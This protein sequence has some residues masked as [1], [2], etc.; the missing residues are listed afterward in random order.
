MAAVDSLTLQVLLSGAGDLGTIGPRT[1]NHAVTAQDELIET[2]FVV[3]TTDADR[4]IPIP[5]EVGT[6][7]FLLLKASVEITFKINGGSEVRTLKAGI[8]HIEATEINTIEVTGGATDSN[9]QMFAV[10]VK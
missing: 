1:F 7:E 10:G 3:E 8:P 9:L 5:G 4:V 2:Q 6:L